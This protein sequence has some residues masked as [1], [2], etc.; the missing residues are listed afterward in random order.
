LPLPRPES[1]CHRSPISE[2]TWAEQERQP[3][4]GCAKNAMPG[5]SAYIDTS[6]LG[7][8]YCPEALSA[9]AETAMRRI[10][11]PVI[12]T[13]S[14]VEFCSLISRKRR[15]KELNERQAK[16]ILDLFGTHVAEG[17]YRRLSLT[18]EH[19]LK[20]RQLVASGIG[21]LHT[22]DAL[23]LAL[24]AAETLPLMT[25]DRDFAN[26]AKRHKAPVILVK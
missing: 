23:H 26:A 2:R 18:T 24:A 14:E 17:F 20:A 12:S 8:Y 9:T 6:V 7:A 15:L 1:R 25:A 10:R 16:Q 4:N 5:D 22:L 11:T 3:R 19:F 21:S 13:L